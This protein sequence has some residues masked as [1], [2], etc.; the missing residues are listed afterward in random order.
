VR[1]PLELVAAFA[2]ATNMDFVPTEALIYEMAGAGQK[3]FAW[4]PPTGHP[5]ESSYWLSTNSM[6][7]RWQLL[8]GLGDN[9]WG[10]GPVDMLSSLD[11]SVRSLGQAAEH[12]SAR[13][14]GAASAPQT[15]G[16]ILTGLNMDGARP[17]ESLKPQDRNN[18][19]RRVAI[20]SAM[21][22]AFQST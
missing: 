14:V 18:P 19:L 2:R 16:A 10:N 21:S 3:L 11:P 12:C 8:Q 5:E 13:I 9:R 6:R 20:L 22:P 17:I 7:R 15:A 4:G 1:R